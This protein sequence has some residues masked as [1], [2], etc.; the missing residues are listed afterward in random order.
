ML[1]YFLSFIFFFVLNEISFTQENSIVQV[2]GIGKSCDEAK[3][4]ALRNAIN[5]AYGSLISSETKISND[6]LISD[7]INILT[8][9][10]VLKYE[11][12]ESCIEKKDYWSI[13]LNVTVSQTELKKFIE[14]KGKSVS[15]SGELL[16]QKTDQEEASSKSELAIIKNLLIQLES[17][18]SEPFD[19]EI[20]IGKITIKD[21]KYCELP[22]EI[23]IKSNLNFYNIY[24][25]L[26]SELEKI[27]IKKID[28]E[29]RKATLLKEDFPIELNSKVYLLR[30]KESIEQIILFYSKILAKMDDYIVV[31]GCLKELYLTAISQSANLYSY[32][33]YFPN[34]GFVSKVVKGQYSTTLDEIA[35]LDRINIISSS[36]LNEFKKKNS[37][38]REFDLLKYS[39]TNPLEFSN[40][41]NNLLIT[42]EYLAKQ[43]EEGNLNL[44]Y[45]IVFSADG[46]NKSIIENIGDLKKDY[47]SIIEK[48]INQIKLNPSKLCGHFIKTTDNINLKFKW[49]SYS[50]LFV[51]KQGINSNYTSYFDNQKLPYGTYLLTIRE[52]KLNDSTYK[53]VFISNYYTRGPLTALYSA[54]IPGWG[55]RRVTYNEKNGWGRFALVA[56]PILMALISKEVSKEYYGKYMNSIVQTDIGK[57]YRTANTLHKSSIILS[58]VAVSFYIYDFVWVF[59]KGVENNS[60]KHKIKEKVKNSNNQIQTQILY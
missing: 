57:Y 34:Q 53:D 27:S 31:D 21:G 38:S 20:S 12:I 43:K 41:K 2:E 17:L 3:N 55:T 33:L 22:A 46:V 36:R 29:F 39:E 23:N 8:S 14:G 6:K 44:N 59:G 51:F 10:N 50:D 56:T 28:Q 7:D 19:Y 37:L 9:G 47:R 49:K 45:N 26:S 16:K 48:S 58:G 18:S 40:F 30:N 11:V 25:K 32:T 15:I 4:D 60:N 13:K 24:L 1:K 52:K 54:I 5:K 42:F 35:S